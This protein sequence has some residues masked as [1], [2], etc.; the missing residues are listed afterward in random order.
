MLKQAIAKK[1]TDDT[2]AIREAC[3]KADRERLSFTA[4]STEPAPH[5]AFR[6]L[7]LLKVV[8]E[9]TRYDGD[10]GLFTKQEFFEVY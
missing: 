2:V 9:K 5:L 6:D 7:V 10:E 3:L 4:P 1:R 8:E